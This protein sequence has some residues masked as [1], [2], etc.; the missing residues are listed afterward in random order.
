[1]GL[2]LQFSR[3][4]GRFIKIEPVIDI[5]RNHHNKFYI[6]PSA[7]AYR[8]KKT[9]TEYTGVLFREG[10]RRPWQARI[11]IGKELVLLGYFGT[12]REAAI[13]FDKVAIKLGR[14]TN[15]LKKH[16]TD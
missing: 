3:Q 5:T 15:I 6:P 8:P 10:C 1:M 12:D 2:T 11:K 16:D 4:L 7:N 14:K 13:A 9:T